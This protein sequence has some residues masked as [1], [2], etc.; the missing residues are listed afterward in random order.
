[1]RWIAVATLAAGCSP[2]GTGAFSCELDTDCMRN[3]IAGTCEPTRFCSFPDPQCASGWRYGELSGD[4]SSV[5][6]GDEPPDAADPPDAVDAAAA[7]DGMVTTIDAAADAA[8]PCAIEVLLPETD[9]G[10]VGSNGGS[11]GP[12]LACGS[13]DEMIGVAVRISNGNT[14]NGGRSAHGFTIAC[15]AVTITESGPVVGTETTFEVMGTGQFGWS[16][17]TQ[18]AITR[19]PAGWILSGIEASRG[20]SDDLFLDVTITCSELGL[21]GATTGATQAIYVAG[22]L[23]NSNNHDAIACGASQVARRLGTRTGAGF[24]ALRV[25]CATPACMP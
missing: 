5:C 24:D 15:A 25:L 14:T 2:F 18:T 3:G 7:I 12:T 16:P 19:C 23:T 10:Q 17:S 4:L 11:V 20:N 22:T 8:P 1:M 6:V 9:E 13:G 21:S